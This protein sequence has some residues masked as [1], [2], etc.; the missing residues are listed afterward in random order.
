M[1]KEIIF[2][3]KSRNPEVKLQHGPLENGFLSIFCTLNL[4]IFG[5]IIAQKI[6]SLGR[7]WSKCEM[8][9]AMPQ[10]KLGNIRVILP[11]FQTCARCEKYL[12]DSKHISLHLVRKWARIFVL[13]HYLFLK[14]HSFPRGTLSENCSLLRTDNVRGQISEHIFAPSGDYCLYIKAQDSCQHL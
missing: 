3:F 1:Y 14:D 8:W 7:D 5:L 11:N 4:D 6:F 9:L 13:G 10:L 2:I 12:K